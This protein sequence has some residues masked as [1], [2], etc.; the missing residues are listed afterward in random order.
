MFVFCVAAAF[1][2]A[3]AA[4]LVSMPVS[5]RVQLWFYVAAFAMFALAFRL[6]LKTERVMAETARIQEDTRRRLAAGLADPGG[7]R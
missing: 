5:Q 6:D 1:V 4:V 2:F 3:A 7:A